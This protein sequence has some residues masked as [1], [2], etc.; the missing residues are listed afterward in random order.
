M[1][2]FSI[3]N[4]LGSVC[5][6][7]R[8]LHCDRRD[9]HEHVHMHIAALAAIAINVIVCAYAVVGNFISVVTV[10]SIYLA[11]AIIIIISS[12]SSVGI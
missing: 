2:H 10:N 11:V 1:L 7:R 8:H 5:C 12:S 9:Y 6:H 3:T 4:V